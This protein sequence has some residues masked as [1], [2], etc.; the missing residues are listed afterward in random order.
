M[1]KEKIDYLSLIKDAHF[2]LEIA[3]EGFCEEHSECCET[4]PINKTR[5]KLYNVIN[6]HML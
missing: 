6:S 2:A 4:C 3:C 1:A 5:K